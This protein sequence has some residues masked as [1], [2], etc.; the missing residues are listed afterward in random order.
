M[1]ASWMGL[2]VPYQ[3]WGQR[4]ARGFFSVC[5][6]FTVPFPRWSIV[7][8]A[9]LMMQG[10]FC[11]CQLSFRSCRSQYCVLLL[12]N[13]RLLLNALS[14]WNVNCSVS[15]NVGRTATSGAAQTRKVTDAKT[16]CC[17]IWT[18]LWTTPWR[19]TGLR[20]EEHGVLSSECCY[21]A[22]YREVLTISIDFCTF[23]WSFQTYSAIIPWNSGTTYW[24]E[25]EVEYFMSRSSG[26]WR[27]LVLWFRMSCCF[28]LQGGVASM[29]EDNINIDPDWPILFIKE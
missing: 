9:S 25:G 18:E 8:V 21:P 2:G 4:V 1:L 14:C 6:C 7:S 16:I 3:M 24:N 12:R 22:F 27:R 11:E 19:Y 28:H 20:S 10:Q 13:V 5:M 26:L 15:R 29:G 23:R 17:R